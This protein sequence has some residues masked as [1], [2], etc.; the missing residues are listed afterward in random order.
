MLMLALQAGRILTRPYV[1]LLKENNVR[2][3]FFELEQAAS[4]QR[5]LPAHMRGVAAFAFVTGWRTPSE[6]LPLEWRQV[7]LK[8]GE[9]RLDAGTTKNGEARVFPLTTELRRVLE[10]QQKIAEQ[11]KRERGLI[12]RHV[13]CYTIGEKAGKGIT[14]GGFNKAWRKA[15]GMPRPDPP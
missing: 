6:I 5:H 10:D 3:G 9:V 8:A 4:V 14:E 13:F 2:K 1:P 7:D 15:R 12:A 11:L